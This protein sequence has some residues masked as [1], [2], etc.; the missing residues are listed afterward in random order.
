MSISKSARVF[1]SYANEDLETVKKVYDGLKK[2]G[3]NVWFDKEHLKPGP[4]KP[5]VEKAISKSRYFVICISEAALRKTGDEPGFQDEE[6]NRAYNIAEKQSDQDFTIVP[7]R[8]EECNRGDTRLSSSQQYDLFN[9]FEGGLDK[10]SVDI[11]GSSLSDSTAKDERTE[12]EKTID[13]LIGKARVASYA[14][15]YDKSMAIL[16]SILALDPE[17]ATTLNDLG[18]VWREKGEYD[19]AIKYHEKA[20]ESYLKNFGEE[21]PDVAIIWNNLGCDCLLKGK[22]DKAIEYYEKSLKSYLKNFGEEHQHVA[23]SWNNLGEVWRQKNECGKAIEYFDKALKSDLK[24]FGEDHPV[25]ATRWNNLGLACRRIGEYVKAIEYHEKALKS[26]LNYF[27]EDHP[28]VAASRNN[29]GLAWKQISEYDKAVECFEKALKSLKKA[30]LHHYAKKVEKHLKLT[31][32]Q[33][34]RE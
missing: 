29:L 2:R 13:H 5:Q 32:E 26:C 19:K 8:L 17:H 15:E 9:D 1:L 14:A 28:K 20:L 30:G 7:V 33:R 22:Y 24:N 3:L 27:G 4:W 6:L 11:G 12:D 23:V 21:H 25:V 16:N 34:N 10:L 31:R 18:E